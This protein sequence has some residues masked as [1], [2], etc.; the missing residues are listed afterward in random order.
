MLTELSELRAQVAEL[1]DL[2]TQLAVLTAHLGPTSIQHP[3][4]TETT[5]GRT[6]AR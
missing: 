3:P 5:T 4:A 2:K 6:D 1:T